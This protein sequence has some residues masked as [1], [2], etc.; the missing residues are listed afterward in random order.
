VN[1]SATGYREIVKRLALTAFVALAAAAAV[2]AY[3]WAS[4]GDT[5]GATAP[6]NSKAVRID[7]S[8]SAAPTLGIVWSPDQKGYG[9]V[10]PTTIYNGGDPTGLVEHV[11]WQRWGEPR[12][13]GTG[14]GWRP[15]DNGGVSESEHLRAKVVAWNLGMCRG[16][17]AYRAINWY[18]PTRG[19]RFNPGLYTNICD[20]RYLNFLIRAGKQT[21]CKFA[22]P[23]GYSLY[24]RNLR[25]G[26]GETCRHANRLVVGV[27][28]WIEGG[29]V[30]PGCHMLG[31]ACV[32][33]PGGLTTYDRS[34]SSYYAYSDASCARGRRRASWRICGLG[35]NSRPTCSTAATTL[36]AAGAQRLPRFAGCKTFFSRSVSGA[37]RPGSIMLACGDGNFYLTRI[38]W[39]RWGMRQALGIGVGH[40]ND[41]VPD[42]ASGHFHTYRVAVKLDRAMMNCA[43]QK[44]AQFTRASWR[45]TGSK[46]RA[47]PRSGSESFRCRVPLS[48][49]G[50]QTLRTC[51]DRWN[52]GNMVSWGPT[53]GSV[54]FRRPTPYERQYLGVPD[55]PRCVV[56]LAVSY[57][58]NSPGGRC[59]DHPVPGHPQFCVRQ[60]QT[61]SCV[62]EHSGAYV[63]PTNAEGSPPLRNQNSTV[64]EHGVLTLRV[65][66]EGTRATP[67]LAW[68]RR[69]PRID[70]FVEPWTS[71]GTL[72]PG[73]RFKGERQGGCFLV[74]ET[75]RSAIS[76]LTRTGSRYNACFPQR[77]DWGAGDLAACG[78]PG[79]TTFVRWTISGR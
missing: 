43:T 55:R 68:Q 30:R 66:I 27:E 69:Y 34:G 59:Y 42:C 44:L 45:F 64:D 39:T 41:C 13:I 2:A 46:P 11:R 14:I 15:P 8:R 32:E 18:Y 78:A 17:L 25:V 28:E 35:V 5:R 22:N 40:Q 6:G 36:T 77:R 47:V 73:L 53:F 52:Q 75:V 61:Y 21:S 38:A 12:A 51:A 24:I 49:S 63:C 58:R 26:G 3:H 72:R 50:A 7:V 54:S 10:K 23:P 76:C 60:S 31:F 62:M 19:D 71:S 4:S 74:A 9:Q 79:G 65:S 29:C 70:G 33:N 16:R 67:P 37:V 1:R 56:A 20:G 57:K 48:P